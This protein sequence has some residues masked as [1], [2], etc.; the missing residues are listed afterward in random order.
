MRTSVAAF[1]VLA[2]FAA[3]GPPVASDEPAAIVVTLTPETGPFLAHLDRGWKP[4]VTDQRPPQVTAAPEHASGWM[5]FPWGAGEAVVA[6]TSQGFVPDRDGDGDL[7]EEEPVPFSG[8]GAP[9]RFVLDL[10]M[11]SGTLPVTL[12]IR[13]R[14]GPYIRNLTR[15]TGKVSLPDGEM[16]VALT[17]YLANG[18]YDDECTST[19]DQAWDCDHIHLDLDRNG[20][21]EPLTAPRGEDRYLTGL[22][23]IDG[24][25]YE[26]EVL[27]RGERLRLTPTDRPLYRIRANVA[28]CYVQLQSAE[29]GPCGL[30]GEDEA[31]WL[32]AGS[33]LLDRYLYETDEVVVR[34]Y[35]RE[36]DGLRYLEVKEDT[37]LEIAGEVRYELDAHVDDLGVLHFRSLSFGPLGARAE[38]QD[39]PISPF[40][41]H[42]R[43]ETPDGR[44]QHSAIVG[45]G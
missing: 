2:L 42:F 21:F 3:L 39:W 30:A 12:E 7:A 8:K 36:E 37:E 11:P 26:C 6:I 31:T 10:D 20:R 35:F 43:V 15:M 45:Y 28:K 34:G 19:I 17:D 24:T 25:L 38:V 44:L 16:T 27:D 29:L 5:V 41:P 18:S 1:T 22:Q 4:P 40:K 23:V 13:T 14:G 33:Y 32:P 9:P